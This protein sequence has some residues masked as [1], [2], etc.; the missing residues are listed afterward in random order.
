V[1]HRQQQD[2]IAAVKKSFPTFFVGGRV[3]EIGSLDINGS[4]RAHFAGCKY[5]GLDVGHGPGVDV[6]CQGQDYDEPSGSFDTVISCETMEHNPYWCETFVNMLRL[7][8]P[9]G[10]V[11]MTCAC[12]GRKEHGTRRT[13]P[14]DAPLIEWDYYGNR[15]ASDFRRSMSF[16]QEFTAWM[17]CSDVSFCDLFFVGFRTGAPAPTNAGMKLR[18]IRWRYFASNLRKYHALKRSLLISIVGERRYMSGPLRPWGRA[19]SMLSK[20]I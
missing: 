18:A 16:R 11:V 7:C 14:Q 13:T 20:D 5:I 15:R 6:V 1:S 9:G 4:V 3:L 8:R 12:P 17:F 10:I 2:F 19:Q